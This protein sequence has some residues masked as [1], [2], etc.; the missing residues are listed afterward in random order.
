MLGLAVLPGVSNAVDWSGSYIGAEVGSSKV[1]M[2]TSGRNTLGGFDNW[3]DDNDKA[4]IFGIKAGKE[5]GDHWLAEISYVRRNGLG[6]M[7][8]N[9]FPGAPGPA[10]FFY[11]TEL[12]TSNTFMVSGYVQP[13][14]ISG[15]K[16]YAGMGMGF[17]SIEIEYVTDGVV[18]GNGDKDWELSW[19]LMLGVEYEIND[20]LDLQFGYR[21]VDLGDS[22]VD[23]TSFGGTPAGKFKADLTANEYMIG[24]RYT[25]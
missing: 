6:D 16:P 3:G 4:S 2:D 22:T 9:S 15:W 1:K 11:D 5:L 13:V 18:E 10:T 24:L 12:S 8:T 14:N 17:S 25:F 21:F 19:Q 23:L 20:S 7:V